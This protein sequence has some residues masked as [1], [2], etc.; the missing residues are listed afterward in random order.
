MVFEVG[1]TVWRK[2]MAGW[3]Q[4]RI[5]GQVSDHDAWYLTT[6]PGQTYVANGRQLRPIDVDGRDPAS[7]G[8]CPTPRSL[9]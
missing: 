7:G 2:G 3:E 5:S 1:M 8:G 4:A 9:R 6:G